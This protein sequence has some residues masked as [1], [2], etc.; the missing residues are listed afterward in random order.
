MRHKILIAMMVMSVFLLM[1]CGRA[2]HGDNQNNNP[3]DTIT[4]QDSITENDT[5]PDRVPADV[6]EEDVTQ[7][8]NLD[9]NGPITDGAVNDSN[10]A[11]SGDGV[12]TEIGDG[13]G[14]AMDG[15]G[16]AVDD[17]MDGAGN[18]V[19]DVMDGAGNTV[20]NVTK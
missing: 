19:N 4:D 2:D 9:G 1:G 6:N 12:I 20:K 11:D 5:I 13:V 14:D 3:G 18:A 7:G 8:D 15:A 16:N 10:G 17:V